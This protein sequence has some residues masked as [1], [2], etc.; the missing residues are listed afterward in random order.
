VNEAGIK[1]KS[2]GGGGDNSIGGRGGKGR[3]SVVRRAPGRK[4]R[5]ERETYLGWKK[6]TVI[7]GEQVSKR[8]GEGKEEIEGIGGIDREREG[9]ISR[10]QPGKGRVG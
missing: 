3:R 6:G 7:K 8:D 2:L 4:E 9:Q 10:R 5:R 1:G